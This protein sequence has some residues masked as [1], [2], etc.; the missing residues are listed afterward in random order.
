MSNSVNQ[1]FAKY[2]KPAPKPLSID[3][4]TTISG[5]EPPTAGALYIPESDE[6]QNA[7]QHMPRIP[8]QQAYDIEMADFSKPDQST[9]IQTATTPTKPDQPTP[10]PEGG[11]AVSISHSPDPNQDALAGGNA[12]KNQT[13]LHGNL[14]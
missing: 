2:K 7:I 9:P 14:N 1:L 5:A 13:T 6:I 11:A 8:S 4:A 3:D 10:L 12:I